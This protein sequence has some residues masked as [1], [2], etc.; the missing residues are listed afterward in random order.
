MG[1]ALALMTAWSRSAAACGSLQLFDA[2]V[3][4]QLEGDAD[5]RPPAGAIT[6]PRR[7]G[8]QFTQPRR[9]R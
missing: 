6:A 3:V 8:W 1:C 7:P 4:R 5:T 9:E 2:R